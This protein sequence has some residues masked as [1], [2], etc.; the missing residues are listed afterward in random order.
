MKRLV[1]L[2]CRPVLVILISVVL[3]CRVDAAAAERAFPGAQGFG[4]FTP[5]G[6]GGKLLR[7]TT[8][9]AT[10]PGSLR[11]ALQAKGPRIVV[12]EVGG[13]IDLGGKS[14][15]VVEP[16]VTLAGQTA[17]APGI[18]LIK[19]SLNIATHDAII[20]HLRVR[21]GEAG[22]PKKSGWEPDG[23][24]IVSAANVIV[25]HCSCTW[26]TDENLS[27]SGPRFEGNTP[28]EWRT[29]TSHHVTFSNCIIA[30]GLSKSTHAK[31]EHSKGSLLHDNATF[32]SVVGN[33]YASN[34]ERNPLAKG[35][36]Q[37][38]IVNNWISNPGRHA[39]HHA[40][41][42]KEW[43]DHPRQTSQLVL[44]GNLL[45]HGP[46]TAPKVTLFANHGNSPVELFLE[47]NLAFGRDRQPVTLVTGKAI[48]TQSHRM[49]WPDGLQALPATKVRDR[50]AR[51]AGAR[52]WDRDP[53]DERI[54]RAA[55]EGQGRII[56]SEQTAGGYPHPPATRAPFKPEEW[57][58]DTLQPRRPILNRQG[59]QIR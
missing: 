5:G 57:N 1:R 33:L 39:I 2:V 41:V 58:L 29:H 52:P 37:A 18:T 47:D 11:E 8:L 10:G 30:E 23:I 36:V 19:G 9:H 42:E 45:E 32:I 51:N 31:G 16:F 40:L 28:A 48:T 3:A 4:A 7:V 35:G 50:V 6:R 21:P 20:Q 17:P 49:S 26:A 55:L 34:V 43:G 22:R 15:T 54:V 38:V 27:A 53:I 24:S 46:D 14:L 59:V 12:F 25:D 44:V 13:V 56:D